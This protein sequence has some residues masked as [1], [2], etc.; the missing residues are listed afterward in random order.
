MTATATA[1]EAGEGGEVRH[2][3]RRRARHQPRRASGV[4]QGARRQLPRRGDPRDPGLVHRELPHGRVVGLRCGRHAGG[5]RAA[6]PRVHGD[7]QRRADP[8]CAD[9]VGA[10]VALRAAL[11]VVEL[12]LARGDDVDPL[13]DR[14]HGHLADTDRRPLQGEHRARRRARSAAAPSVSWWTRCRRGRAGSRSPSS[15]CARQRRSFA[16]PTSPQSASTATRPSTRGRAPR[17]SGSGHAAEYFSL[18]RAHPLLLQSIVGAAFRVFGQSDFAAR[19]VVAMVFGVGSVALTYA[20]GRLVSGAGTALIAAAT[21]ALLPYH[22]IVSRQVL[23]DTAMGFFAVLSLVLV[24][25]WMRTLSPA[26]LDRCVRGGRPRDDLE[27][28]RGADRPGPLLR[29]LARRWMER[30]AQAA[31]F[32]GRRPSTR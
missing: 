12:R 23:V 15:R 7:E 16:S 10:D 29:R 14:R 31:R 20:L 2:R 24:L 11:H 32:D 19:F 21:C 27:G 3:R 13:R 18:F 26:A 30:V 8:A 22:V 4:H 25:R 17:C 6:L 1:P 28:S 9:D 5:T